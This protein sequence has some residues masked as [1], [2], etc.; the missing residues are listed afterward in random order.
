[1]NPADGDTASPNPDDA[2]PVRLVTVNDVVSMNLGYFRKAAGLSQQEL[3][4]RIGWLKSV[5]A[6]AER[7]WAGRRTRN[8]TADDLIDIAT[9]LGIPVAGLFLPPEDDGVAVRYVV[10]GLHSTGLRPLG[11]L[12]PLVLDIVDGDSPALSAYR[13]RA[14]AAKPRAPVWRA[15]EIVRVFTDGTMTE[16]VLSE[17]ETAAVDKAFGD[18]HAQTIEKIGRLELERMALERRV[19][20]LREFERECRSGLRRY[21]EDQYRAFWSGTEGID[22]DARLAA[23]H[24]EAVDRPHV[25]TV[26]ESGAEDVELPDAI[27]A[28]ISEAARKPMLAG[29]RDLWNRGIPGPYFFKE[30]RDGSV[31]VTSVSAKQSVR[32]ES[33]PAGRME[34]EPTGPVEREPAGR[35]RRKPHGHVDREPAGERKRLPAVL[36]PGPGDE[37]AARPKMPET[38]GQGARAVVFPVLGAGH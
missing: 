17:E 33:D 14:I 21:L 29:L 2:P 24:D 12:L 18:L 31:T 26:P 5:V 4:E 32:V 35:K 9:G 15:H 19:E 13:R 8:F 37:E 7:S 34:T 1:M 38:Q 3:G 6:T 23:L 30:E 16:A 20:D 11:D 25:I 28:F 27:L 22:P 10:D 36:L